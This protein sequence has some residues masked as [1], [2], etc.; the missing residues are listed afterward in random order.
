MHIIR[1]VYDQSRVEEEVEAFRFGLNGTFGTLPVC[2]TEYDPKNSL[3]RFIAASSSCCLVEG[4][5]IASAAPLA[6]SLL[7]DGNWGSCGTAAGSDGG[8]GAPVTSPTA[9]GASTAGADAI[10][11]SGD[12]RVFWVT[13]ISYCAKRQ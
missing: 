8:G 1:Q 13:S 5:P 10:N 3:P 9:D 4:I 2:P 6:V 11:S 12:A 7:D